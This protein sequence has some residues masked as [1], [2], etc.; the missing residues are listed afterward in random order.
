MNNVTTQKFV[1][2]AASKLVKTTLCFWYEGVGFMS[3]HIKY[4]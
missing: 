4:I 3:S 1:F 2:K